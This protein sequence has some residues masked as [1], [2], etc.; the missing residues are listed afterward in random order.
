ME[1]RKENNRSRGCDIDASS[2]VAEDSL[3]LML[4]PEEV[5]QR[6]SKHTEFPHMHRLLKD[7]PI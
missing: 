6:K 7:V 4:A 5:K 1:L 2:K 3:L